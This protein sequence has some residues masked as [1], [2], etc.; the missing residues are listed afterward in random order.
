MRAIDGA[1][2]DLK[3]LDLLAT[4]DSVMHRL[5]A[6]AKVLTTLVF[7]ISVVSFGRYEFTALFPFFIYPVVAAS[8]ANL[9][10]GYLIKKIAMVIP[11]AFVV[12]MLNP[13]F[14]RQP[15]AQLGPLAVSGGWISCA[16][17]IV[18]AVLTVGAAFI[19][20]GMTGFLSVCQALERLGTPKPFTVQLLFLYRYIFVLT[21]EGA[22]ASRAREL[23]SCGR[24]GLG[25]SSFGS[26][27]GHLLIR[28]WLR[29]ERIHM[30]MLARGFTG[31]FHS[32]QLTRFGA[33]E[34]FFVLGWSALFVILRL[35]NA[36]SFMGRLLA[37]LLT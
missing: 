25:L 14:D 13:L 11:F 29:A 20:V 32:G 1:V 9:P 22:R 10:G 3:R 35:E 27:I 24:K 28:T 8:L 34:L 16:S 15:M 4:G 7:I 31:E 26:L 17:I 18:R 2:A 33:R 23:R 21:E 36:A 19:L 37:G 6:R 30:A 5:D 12:G